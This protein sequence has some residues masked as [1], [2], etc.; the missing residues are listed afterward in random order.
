MKKFNVLFSLA[1]LV[2]GLVVSSCNDDDEPQSKTDLLTSK[3]WIQTSAV[4]RLPAG[5]EV[6]VTAEKISDCRKD[7]W[8]TFAKDGTCK[9]DIG[10]VPCYP[11]E[12][13][14]NI[15]TWSWK[16]NETVLSISL[17]GDTSDTKLVSIT[18]NTLKLEFGTQKYDTNMDGIDDTEVPVIFTLTAK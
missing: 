18:A 2:M 8:L 5:V 3:D 16:E 9:D 7:N 1:L 17:E 6:D 13:N 10:A 12:E 4:L 11:S 15:G 14:N